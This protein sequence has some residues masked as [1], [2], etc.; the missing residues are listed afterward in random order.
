KK[1]GKIDSVKNNWAGGVAVLIALFTAAFLYI[2]RG[3]EITDLIQGWGPWGV[4]LAVFL[5]AAIFL[6]PIPSEGIIVLYLKIYGVYFGTLYSWIGSIISTVV[7]Y[8]IART[9]GQKLM[10]KLI[11]QERFE[12]IDDWVENKGTFGLL[13]ARFIPVP[14]FFVNCIAG[15][16]PSVKLWRFTWTA[17]VAIIP[18]FLGIALVFT[19]VASGSWKWIIFGVIVEA[20]CLSAGYYINRQRK[21]NKSIAD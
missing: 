6:T 15:T 7:F 19:G 5:I 16:L 14:A 10:K 21:K 20:V 18:Y 1:K 12:A 9:Y 8:F 13:I 3:N 4:V 17:A 2:D 11:T